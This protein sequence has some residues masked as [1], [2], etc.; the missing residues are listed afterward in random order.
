MNTLTCFARGSR[1]SR[2]K[3]DSGTFPE[4][5]VEALQRRAGVG[6]N[7]LTSPGAYNVDVTWTKIK[8]LKA[9]SRT[10][11]AA[12]DIGAPQVSGGQ[13]GAIQVGRINFAGPR[14]TWNL[15]VRNLLNDTQVRAV[16][17]VQTSP[18]FGKAISFATGRSVTAG[19]SFNF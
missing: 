14:I 8:A 19:L 12:S 18:L 10:S 3:H 4:F 11:T 7:T 6:R 2:S 9:E 16:S 15:T 17:G 5:S 1:G 13:G